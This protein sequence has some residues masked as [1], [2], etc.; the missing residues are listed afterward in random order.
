MTVQNMRHII[1][2]TVINL[3]LAWPK[4]MAVH[5][6][7]GMSLLQPKAMSRTGTDIPQFVANAFSVS[8]VLSLLCFLT[9]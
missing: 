2:Y 7:R 8:F 1:F 3:G 6:I 5:N 4:L 9:L